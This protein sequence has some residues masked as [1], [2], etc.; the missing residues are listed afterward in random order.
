MDE[1]NILGNVILIKGTEFR[2]LEQLILPLLAGGIGGLITFL[3]K[4]IEQDLEYGKVSNEEYE[5]QKKSGYIYRFRLYPKFIFIGAIAGFAAVALLNPQG[6]KSQVSV[7]ALLAGLSG[8]SYLSRN[9]LVD[10]KD[11]T[12]MFNKR[13]SKSEEKLDVFKEYSGSESLF[14]DMEYYFDLEDEKIEDEG[15]DKGDN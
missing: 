4:T 2:L 13:K 5:K 14:S 3:L 15:D 12:N 10:G 1:Y 11:E 7:L 9:A 6:D 8:I